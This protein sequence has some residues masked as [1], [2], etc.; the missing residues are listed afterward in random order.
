MR[1]DH[2]IRPPFDELQGGRAGS[3]HIRSGVGID[4]LQPA[5]LPIQHHAALFVDRVDG[6][7]LHIGGPLSEGGQRTGQRDHTAHQHRIVKDP[8]SVLRLP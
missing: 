3:R 8:A 6:R 7:L 5:A 4:Q 2:D 1:D